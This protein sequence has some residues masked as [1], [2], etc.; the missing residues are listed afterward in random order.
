MDWTVGTFGTV[1]N[2]ALDA[3]DCLRTSWTLGSAVGADKGFRTTVSSL[4]FYHKI[5]HITSF[6]RADKRQGLRR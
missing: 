5:S 6:L 4:S 3:G 1:G 2:D